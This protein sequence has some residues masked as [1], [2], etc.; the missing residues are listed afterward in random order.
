ML[1]TNGVKGTS[2]A[3]KGG[4]MYGHAIDSG[5]GRV[6]NGNR[7]RTTKSRWRCAVKQRCGRRGY[8]RCEPAVKERCH[9]HEEI[10]GGSKYIPNE[11]LPDAADLLFPCASRWRAT[12]SCCWPSTSRY[13][14]WTM[15]PREALE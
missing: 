2:V 3:G 11:P 7:G 14:I 8:T 12:R 10:G 5:L 4:E 9:S 1:R 15:D 13:Q 6:V